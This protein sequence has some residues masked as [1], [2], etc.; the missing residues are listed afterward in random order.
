M[1]AY[2]INPLCKDAEIYFYDFLFEEDNPVPPNIVEHLNTCPYCSARINSLD[3][4]ISQIDSSPNEEEPIW[5]NSSWLKLHFKYVGKPVHCYMIKPFLPGFLN[6]FLQTKIP[7]PITVHLDKCT[8]CKE[9]LDKIKQFNL[10]DKQL[11]ILSQLYLTQSDDNK[12]ACSEAKSAIDAIASMNFGTTNKKALEH[13][14]TCPD[15]RKAVQNNRET[16]RKYLILK[17]NTALMSFPCDKVFSGELFDYVIPLALDPQNDQYAK[18]RNFFTSHV[19]TCPICLERMQ[20]MHE[21]LYGIAE[22][23]ESGIVTTYH[24]EESSKTEET[25]DSIYKGFPINIETDIYKKNAIHAKKTIGSKINIRPLAKIGFAAAAVILI[26][27]VLMFNISSAK[28]VSLE[29]IYKL[30]NE[31]KSV[32]IQTYEPDQKESSQEQWISKTLNINMI[33]TQ[34]EI[35]LWDLQNKIKTTK[36]VNSSSIQTLNLVEDN[37]SKM[38]T[39]IDSSFGLLPFD[40]IVNIPDDATWEKISNDTQPDIDIYNLIWTE[41]T[42]GGKTVFW[43]WCIYINVNTMAIMKTEWHTKSSSENIYVL[44]SRKII[45]MI[46]DAQIKNIIDQSL[47]ISY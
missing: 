24:I 1:I 40:S 28:A 45:E 21:V 13:V 26:G 37:R 23:Q 44:K 34:E 30:V 19:M 35:V 15:C 11:T 38:E 16:T 41:K 42:Y 10:N 36:H 33:K 29:A 6:P 39:R 18:F 31:I 5:V 4:A 20:Q 7:T 9:D 8:E 2:N 22:R 32:H 3:E 27:S 46:D 43:K 12:I 25:N 14:C 17:E 47:G